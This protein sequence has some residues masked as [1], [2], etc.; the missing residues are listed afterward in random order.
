[1]HVRLAQDHR[2]G[3]HQ[4]L[5]GGRGFARDELLE[6]GGAGGVGHAGHV[7]VVLHD[8]RHTVQGPPVPPGRQISVGPLGRGQRPRS[9]Q[10]DEGV[11]V[12]VGLRARQVGL[13]QLHAG[14]LLVADELRS[15]DHAQLGDVGG[16][17]GGTRTA[18]RTERERQDGG[19]RA[20]P[21]GW[22][23]RW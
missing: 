12:A 3:L 20:E 10:R 7:H 17:L 21:H 22:S 6:A 1:V 18:R 15:V 19:D 4:S 2:A 13:R 5:R 8:E 16:A 14:D 23:P 11:E 9:I